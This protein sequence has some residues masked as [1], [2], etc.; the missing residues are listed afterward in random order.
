MHKHI[1]GSPLD[2]ESGIVDQYDSEY[3]EYLEVTPLIHLRQIHLLLVSIFSLPSSGTPN[4]LF[5]N[6]YLP[7]RHHITPNALNYFNY[8]LIA[9]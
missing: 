2:E 5:P 6:S 7:F 3:S 9:L 4:I 8:Q 1:L